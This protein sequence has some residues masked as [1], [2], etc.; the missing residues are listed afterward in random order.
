MTRNNSMRAEQIL[1][2]LSQKRKISVT[3]L[4][5]MLGVSL[6]T[7]RKDLD[8]LEKRGFIIRRQGYAEINDSDD[9]SSRLSFNYDIKK[10]IAER[11]AEFIRDGDTVM[12][13]SGSCCAILADII[14]KTRKNITLITNSCFIAD[15]TRQH[16]G[17]NVV[18]LGGLYQKESQ[19]LVGPMIRETAE[20]YHVGCFFIGTDGYSEATG[21]TNKDPL[22][23]QAVR[24]MASAEKIYILTENE[25]CNNI[26]TT[27]L[28]IK[29]K[30]LTLISNSA[31][32]DLTIKSLKEKNIAIIEAI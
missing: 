25:K 8:L 2:I 24:D 20:S 15:Y 29:N 12:I 18:L 9:I 16:P 7:V 3:E 26:G 10:R 13:E 19:C 6:V 32:P 27:P 30:P 14:G 11:A 17:I 4:S 1:N 23:A 22:R 31:I 21:F 5:D 28:N